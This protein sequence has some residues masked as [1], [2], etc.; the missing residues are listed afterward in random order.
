M[1]SRQ[2]INELTL[3]DRSG[4]LIIPFRLE[5][6]EPEGAFKYYLYKTHWLNAFDNAWREKLGVLGERVLHNLPQ[7]KA[8]IPVPTLPESRKQFQRLLPTRIILGLPLVIIAIA[9]SIFVFYKAN[10]GKPDPP[11][12]DAVNLEGQS[13]KI[14][15]AV[16]TVQS[17]YRY[18][19]SRQFKKAMT[20]VDSDIAWQFKDDFFMQFDR[21]SIQQLKQTGIIGSTVNLEGVVVFVWPDGSM[22]K[23]KRTFSV[24][25]SVMPPRLTATEF[26]GIVQSR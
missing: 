21:V 15:K 4:V 9:T 1:A 18:I 8:G 25:T 6:I 10:P 26:G 22:Q 23:E 13:K 24:N 19:S 20:F 11:K 14:D 16:E 3:A 7:D 2:V 12:A 17:I 5:D